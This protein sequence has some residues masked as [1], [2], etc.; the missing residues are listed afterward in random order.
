MA[1]DRKLFNEPLF[2]A[3]GVLLEVPHDVA[4]ASAVPARVIAAGLDVSL[5][6]IEKL[7]SHL[8]RAGLLKSVR[9][10]RGGFMLTRPP[11][12]IAVADVFDAVNV[13]PPNKNVRG[14]LAQAQSLRRKLAEH[15]R[16]VL[17]KISL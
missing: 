17:A 9:G 1:A 15:N 13:N 12:Q 16:E 8:L 14:S 5:S 3:L 4:D 6:Y 11:D 2:T 10:P 7:T